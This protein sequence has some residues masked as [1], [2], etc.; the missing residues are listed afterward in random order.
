MAYSV[1]YVRQ[2][3]CP[4]GFIKK[5]G[6]CQCYPLFEQFGI[7]DC[8]INKQAVLRPANGW[9]YASSH[10]NYVISEQCP[11]H[12]CKDSIFYLNLSTPEVQCQFNRSGLLCGQCQHG[13][14]TVLGSSHCQ[15]CSNIYLLLI[16]PIAIAGF[17]LVLLLFLLNLTVTDGTICA[18]ILYANVISVNSTIFFPSHS[19]SIVHAFISLANLDLGVKTCFYNGMDDYVKM[20]LQLVFPLYLMLIAILL[21][22]TSRYLSII[23][24]LTSHRALP[25]L[26]TLFLLSY[27]KI[28]RTVCDVLFLYSSITHLPSKH[29]TQVWSIDASVP[30]FGVKFVLLFVACF[31]LFL[32]LIPFNL[33]LLFTRTLSRL[34][35]VNKFKP[36]LDAYQG[37]Y[38]IKFYDWTGLQLVMRTVLFGLSSLSR[39]I[40]LS[41]SIIILSIVNVV[42]TCS[43]PFK[44]KVK[45][46]QELLLIINLLVIYTFALSSP[47]D[48]NANVVN[49][50]I[51]LA[52][53]QFSVIVMYNLLIYACSE[54]FRKKLLSLYH[55]VLARLTTRSHR[56]LQ[57]HGQPFELYRCN[58][59]DVTYNYHEYQEPLIGQ[60]YYCK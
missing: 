22:I 39:N 27:T 24:K 58:I 12:Y 14:S 55:D 53:A 20:W 43:K 31:I 42:H 47:N 50:M 45:N 15:H 36:L 28:L 38:K 17:V 40:N 52:V 48:I 6:T 56:N 46:Y 59:P 10:D 9:I 60:E 33:I 8:N 4:L 29:T 5:E 7:I 2:L 41:S 37:P 26:A 32:I 18:F 44:S 1:F 30:L 3:L 16:I 21:I 54:V 57:V 23:Q 25:V 34:K 49:I 11:F 13:L 19:T 51:S 35:F